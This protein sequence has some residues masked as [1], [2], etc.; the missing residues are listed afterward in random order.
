MTAKEDKI[1]PAHQGNRD[2]WSEPTPPVKVPKTE[3]CHICGKQH[4]GTGPG[5]GD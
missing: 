5:L 3:E 4:V 2:K 1:K